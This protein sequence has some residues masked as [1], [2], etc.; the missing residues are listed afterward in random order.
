MY[1]GSRGNGCDNSW[2]TLTGTVHLVAT[3]DG[4]DIYDGAL[5][6][7]AA[8]FV[9]GMTVWRGWRPWDGG[10]GGDCPG[11]G[12][13]FEYTIAEV[14]GM[15]SATT[16]YV[17]DIPAPRARNGIDF[18]LRFCNYE[19]S[20]AT[21]CGVVGSVGDRFKLYIPAQLEIEGV[22]AGDVAPIAIGASGVTVDFAQSPGGWVSAT[23]VTTEPP[24][25]VPAYMPHIPGYWEVNTTL[26]NGSF[27]AN[28]SITYDP[29]LL[30]PTVSE[31]GLNILAYDSSA[32]VWLPLRQ[33][34]VDE[35]ANRITATAETHFAMYI[36]GDVVV[37]D[38]AG[39]TPSGAL[40]IRNCYPNP[41]SS[42]TAFEYN[43]PVASPVQ[44]SAFD[45]TGRL[46]TRITKGIQAAGWHVETF[47]ATDERGGALGNGVYFLQ[48]RANGHVATTKIV[49][50]H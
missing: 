38:V 45:V 50:M 30:P 29:A 46:A 47:A 21:S 6:P 24:Y 10:F 26:P 14:S 34:S 3:V 39:K 33:T 48:V 17:H 37:S 49:V 27:A 42:T 31:S 15:F 22:A 20:W 44:I 32:H 1:F 16:G 19:C 13:N 7:T 11:Y 41:F 28:V 35:A 18:T 9:S 12:T 2:G 8:H 36:V 4:V 43:L 40:S 25:L 23:H 5:L